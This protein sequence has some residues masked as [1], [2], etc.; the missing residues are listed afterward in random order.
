MDKVLLQ[1]FIVKLNN[2]EGK[3][4]LLSLTAYKAA[5]TLSR[6]KPSTLVSF[7]VKNRNLYTLWDNYKEDIVNSLGLCYF[8]LKKTDDWVLVLFYDH[9]MLDEVTSNKT[10]Q[11][12][13]RRMGYDSA[14]TLA[15]RLNFLRERFQMMCPHEIG[16]FL[17]I[18]IKDVCSFIKHKGENFLICKYWKVYHNAEHAEHLFASYD[19]AKTDMIYKVIT[20]AS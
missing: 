16:I 12:F 7:S 10:N 15:K 2:I 20:A 1:K 18:P 19:R 3:E 11:A 8:E 5:P 14:L 4:Y 9:D 6:I 13:L 17:G